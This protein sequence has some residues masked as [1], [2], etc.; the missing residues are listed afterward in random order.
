MVLTPQN[1]TSRLEHQTLFLDTNVFSVAYRYSELV[2]FL[3]DLRNH[4]CALVTI[5]S[6]E[7]EVTR[8]SSS[9]TIFNARAKA[10]KK[11]ITYIDPMLFIDDV[12]D[13]SVVMANLQKPEKSQY[14]D[15]LLAAC[16]YQFRTS[17]PRLMTSDIAS[18]P[19]SIFDRE[20]VVTSENHNEIIN[21]GIFSLNDAN[22]EKAAAALL[23]RE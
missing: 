7:F 6:V 11:L 20:F 15:F 22:Y 3:D 8:G 2:D 12:D 19:P 14:T 21:Y 4:D 23:S 1:L 5:P 9:L 17:K 10:L 13:F 16:L 18:M